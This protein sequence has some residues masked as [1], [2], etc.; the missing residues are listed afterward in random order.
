VSLN[1]PLA[2]WSLHYAISREL[3]RKISHK[4]KKMIH[5]VEINQRLTQL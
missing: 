3:P 5:I 1:I 4:E 2:R